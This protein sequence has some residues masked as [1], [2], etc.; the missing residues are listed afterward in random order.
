VQETGL[1]CRSSDVMRG[2]PAALAPEGDVRVGRRWDLARVALDRSGAGRATQRRSTPIVADEK[3]CL[4]G[5]VR[6]WTWLAHVL[7]S[8][9]DAA[10]R[11]NR[12][13]GELLVAIH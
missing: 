9:F 13:M 12:C 8:Y 1:L 7:S 4:G 11:G 10:V 6:V 2:A 5:I 3:K